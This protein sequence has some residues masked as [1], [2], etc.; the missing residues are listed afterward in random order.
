[1]KNLI[2]A[3][4]L[5]MTATTIAQEQEDF[6]LTCI[7]GDSRNNLGL[8][9]ADMAMAIE[10]HRTAVGKIDGLMNVVD[11]APQNFNTANVSGSTLLYSKWGNSGMIR[12]AGTEYKVKNINYDIQR[13]QFL[14]KLNDG[15]MIT[16]DFNGIEEIRVS[17]DILKVLYD[18]S[19]RAYRV[20][21]VLLE[22]PEFMVLK[23]FDLKLVEGSGNPMLN[24]NTNKIKKTES[25]FVK[26]SSDIIAY[27]GSKR[28]IM[29]YIDND[30]RLALV[31]ALDIRISGE[32][33]AA[34]N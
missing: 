20:F 2:I 13:G 21:Q 6:F 22:E 18:N 1:M 26:Q 3:F 29:K 25:L 12:V 16:Y 4:A 30:D 14:T 17:D 19:S 9:T 5:L 33:L 23:G 31:K 7:S 32:A 15:R 10:G 27:K 11:L 28:K 24:R 8:R 34:K